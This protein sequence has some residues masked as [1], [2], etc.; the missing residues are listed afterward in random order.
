[1]EIDKEK[2]DRFLAQF[3]KLILTENLNKDEYTMFVAILED[4]LD[5]MLESHNLKDTKHDA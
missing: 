4:T 1:M 3:Q 2:M 5:D